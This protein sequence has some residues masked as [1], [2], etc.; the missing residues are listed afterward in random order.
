[1]QCN[2]EFI[3]GNGWYR[4]SQCKGEWHEDFGYMVCHPARTDTFRP[5]TPE[6]REAAL[7]A[8]LKPPRARGEKFKEHYPTD[9]DCWRKDAEIDKRFLI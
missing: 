9:W 5:W 7:K 2:K 4:C 8:A 3:L 1:M 6:Q